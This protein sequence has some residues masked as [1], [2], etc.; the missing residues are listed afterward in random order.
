MALGS[1]TVRAA[2][3][4]QYTIGSPASFTASQLA[5][6]NTALAR[7]EAM[8]ENVITG[9][10]PG[11]TVTNLPITINAVTTGL[12][13]ASF[14]SS[15][16]QSGF[17]VPTSGF[18]NM[19]VN[20]IENFASWQGVVVPPV[21]N[22]RNYLDELLAHETGHVLGIGTTWVQNNVY[23]VDGQFRYTGQHGLAAYKKEFDATATYVPIENAGNAG[24]PGAHWDQLMRSSFQEGTP[25]PAD[26]FLL[27]PRVGVTDRFGR[28]RGLELMT[29]AIDPDYGEPFLSRY[30]VESLRDLGYAVTSI[31]D[32]NGDGGVDLADLA[33]VSANI[34][35][36]GLQTDSMR[37][38]DVNGDRMVDAADFALVRAVI[39]EPSTLALAAVVALACCFRR[40][41]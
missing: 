12:A 38:G 23:V 7:S 36:T 21:T 30:T 6:L 32:I 27:D 8:W 35:M 15:V 4:I 28:D 5:H 20:E 19:N 25:P 31:E 22:G 18:I 17:R 1:S 11:V 26:P 40:R 13:S 37:F 41:L 34:G 29:G 39:P 14:N 24:T 9:Y 16:F 2:F 33:V 10:Q 3:N